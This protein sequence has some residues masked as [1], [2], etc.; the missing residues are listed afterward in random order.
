M[1]HSPL[2]A[3]LG[4]V[5]KSEKSNPSFKCDYCAFETNTEEDVLNHTIIQHTIQTCE[6]CN[7]Q[8]RDSK[9]L[10]DHLKSI[11]KQAKSH[12]VHAIPFSIL[13]FN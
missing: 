12:V 4:A 10:E 1:L 9:S 7:F 13:C 11:H 3:H 6:M 8:C 2:E 5:H